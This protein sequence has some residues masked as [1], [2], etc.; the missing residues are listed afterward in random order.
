MSSESP[1]TNKR[2]KY[3]PIYVLC[4]P[5]LILL[6]ERDPFQSVL[7]SE[8][9]PLRLSI[10]SFRGRPNPLLISPPLSL[11]IATPRVYHPK[12]IILSSRPLTT[13]LFCPTIFINCH[14]IQLPL[15]QLREPMRERTQ[16]DKTIFYCS[17][18]GTTHRH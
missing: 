5:L 3:A 7:L 1:T 10:S 13:F 2:Q 11:H 12:W 15:H 14:P 9:D 4:R 6:S 16:C 17:Y 18:F 8:Q